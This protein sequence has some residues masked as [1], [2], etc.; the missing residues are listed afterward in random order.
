MTILE[1]RGLFWWNDQAIPKK[2][3]APDTAVGGKLTIGDNGEARL[4]MDTMMPGNKHP[5]QVLAG[6][7]QPVNRSIQ[8]LL[9]GDAGYVHLG[10]LFQ[11]GG[12]MRTSNLSHEG[13]LAL[14]CLVSKSHFSPDNPT[15]ERQFRSILVELEGFEEWLWLQGISVK[16]STKRLTAKYKQP[17]NYQFDVD[18]GKVSVEYDLYGPSFSSAYERTV[19]LRQTASV[20][21]TP[22]YRPALA[23]CQMY[24]QQLE[25][26]LMLL[27]SS[28]RSLEWPALVSANGKQHARFYFM[29][30]RSDAKA[31]K[32]HECLT[33]FPTIAEDFG[34][35]LANLIL[36]RDEFGPGFYLYL[37]IR[38]GMKL[39]VEH[40]F[41]NLVWGLE[42]FDRRRSGQD[43]AA[44]KIAHKIERILSQVE[45]TKDRR[46]LDA[47]LKGA[48][49]PNLADRLC[50]TFSA[51]PLSFDKVGLQ[52]FC[53][54]CADRRNDISHFGG[55]R[56]KGQKYNDFMRDIDQK[57]DALAGLY[58]LHLLSEIGVNKTQLAFA[59]N[60]SWP[61]NKIERDLRDAGILAKKPA[62]APA[63]P[64]PA[65]TT[66]KPRGG[67]K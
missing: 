62:P 64:Q 56:D 48:G 42:A 33:N 8:G 55:I 50:R 54:D 45:A 19:T 57:A 53:K 26:L 47:M 23:A 5:F 30:N 67:R 6:N 37:G 17:D 2:Q 61:M 16:R 36:K 14:N 31:P 12:R 22:K 18:F 25:E 49:G 29:R 58:Q 28:D 35:L 24:Y 39:F 38:R 41:V 43:K 40:R 4:E 7:G 15:N 10:G 46:W 1:D 51:L 60:N 59:T 13:Y 34:R 27:T 20:R 52:K 21:I 3:F 44:K 63:S 9:R 66:S 11:S 32:A 65:A